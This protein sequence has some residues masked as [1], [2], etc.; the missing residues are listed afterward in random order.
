VELG[1]YVNARTNIK[2]YIE[3]GIGAISFKLNRGEER[4]RLNKLFTNI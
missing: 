3:G 2:K 4:K 1:D